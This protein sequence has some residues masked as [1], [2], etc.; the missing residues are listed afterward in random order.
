MTLL[1]ESRVRAAARI[2]RDRVLKSSRTI[3]AE[4]SKTIEDSFNIFLSHAIADAEIVLG[5]R[6]ILQRLGYSVYVDW[7]VDTEMDR[8]RVTPETATKLK[9]RMRQCESLLYLATE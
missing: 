2:T 6:S 4:D 5:A 3:L 1:T 7:I 8:S 9:K